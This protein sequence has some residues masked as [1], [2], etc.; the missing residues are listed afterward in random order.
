MLRFQKGSLTK[1]AS[2]EMKRRSAIFRNWV[3]RKG[4]YVFLALVLSGCAHTYSYPYDPYYDDYA[5]HHHD[6]DFD[7]DHRWGY[8]TEG[9]YYDRPHHRF[10]EHEAY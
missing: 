10:Y 5:Y 9:A 1:D 6:H 7:Y 4:L 2:V 3:P 8:S